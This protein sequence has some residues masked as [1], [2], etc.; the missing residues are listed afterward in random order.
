MKERP[1]VTTTELQSELDISIE[2]AQALREDPD[3]LRKLLRG[4]PTV[5]IGSTTTTIS[6]TS[7]PLR[8]LQYANALRFVLSD[9]PEVDKVCPRRMEQTAS[10]RAHIGGG[11]P[12]DDEYGDWWADAPEEDI[13]AVVPEKEVETAPVVVEEVPTVVKVKTGRKKK[14]YNYFNERLQA[15]DPVTFNPSNSEYTKKCEHEHQ[16]IILSSDQLDAIRAEHG[17]E[18]DPRMY[19]TTD[20]DKKRLLDYSDPAGVIMCPEYWCMKD[21]VPLQASQLVDGK[22]PICNLGVQQ[23]ATD[24]PR[25]LPVVSRDKARKYPGLGKYVS[26]ANGRRMPCCYKTPEKVKL[27]DSAPTDDKYY[28]LSDSKDV[29]PPLRLAFLPRDV[30]EALM[31]S[32]TYTSFQGTEKRIQSPMSGFFRVGIGRPS[33]NLPKLLGVTVEIP[34][35]HENPEATLKCSFAYK[36]KYQFRDCVSYS[37]PFTIF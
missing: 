14:M 5:K 34:R 1:D 20:E 26:P 31:I 33:E 19:Y 11:G 12:D 29:I 24:D 32:E 27:L 6:S 17:E 36:M 9:A 8:V 23:K 30:L 18:Y 10:A 22:C 37:S 2:E 35:P 21:E 16:P 3:L 15:F 13:P 28:I 25:E 4:F 7:R